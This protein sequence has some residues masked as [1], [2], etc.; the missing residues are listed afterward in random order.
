M[1]NTQ[2]IAQDYVTLCR[3][4]KEQEV[5]QKYYSENII[6]IEMEGGEFERVEGMEGIA[7]K[8]AWWE[9]NFEVHSI[10]VSDPLVADSWFAVRFTMDTTH[11]PSGQRS[12]MGELAVMQVVDGKIVKE[13]FFYNKD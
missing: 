4:G 9:E 7:K 10:E 8:G 2:E 12:T 3:A 1:M 13:Q 11:K 6:S 5:H